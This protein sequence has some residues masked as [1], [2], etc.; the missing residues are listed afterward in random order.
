MEFLRRFQ[1]PVNH[2][3]GNNKCDK[4]DNNDNK[5]DNNDTNKDAIPSTVVNLEGLYFGRKFLGRFQ[6]DNH[7]NGNNN[8]DT[9]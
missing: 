4:S 2:K 1:S 8:K 6:M 9:D 5:S 7:K 3:N